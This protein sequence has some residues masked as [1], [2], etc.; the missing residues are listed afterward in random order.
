LQFIGL[1]RAIKRAHFDPTTAMW[2]LVRGDRKRNRSL[3][4]AQ[5]LFE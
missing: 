4:N 1:A 2:R 5:A 3:G